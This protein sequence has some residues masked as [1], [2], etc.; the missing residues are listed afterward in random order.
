V[1]TTER[2]TNLRGK[3]TSKKKRATYES[4]GVD[5]EAMYSNTHSLVAA[6]E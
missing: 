4:V 6:S 1:P 3:S 5:E 2:A